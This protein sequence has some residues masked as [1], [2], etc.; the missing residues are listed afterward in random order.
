MPYT[1]VF[2]HMSSVMHIFFMYR[3]ISDRISMSIQWTAYSKARPH[4]PSQYSKSIMRTS[5]KA[6]TPFLYNHRR[7]R[8]FQRKRGGLSIYQ[9]SLLFSLFYPP[10]GRFLSC[11]LLLSGEKPFSDLPWDLSKKGV[12][13]LS[14]KFVSWEVRK[15]HC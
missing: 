2:F 5:A 7:Q 9:A 6:F 10:K 12:G 3:S 1:V 15:R 13:W 14:C 11:C 4:R 8:T